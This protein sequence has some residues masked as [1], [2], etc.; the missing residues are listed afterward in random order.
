MSQCTITKNQR[1]ETGYI[2]GYTKCCKWQQP[3]RRFNVMYITNSGRVGRFVFSLDLFV[4]A[5]FETLEFSFRGSVFFGSMEQDIMCAI[6]LWLWAFFSS[7]TLPETM[8][9]FE[10][11]E[12]KFLFSYVFCSLSS[13]FFLRNSTVPQC[14]TTLTQNARR[15][16]RI[17]LS[18]TSYLAIGCK[19]FGCF[20]FNWFFVFC[21]RVE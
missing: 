11:S 4:P 20:W 14:M 13:N 3:F 18:V 9:A 10:A 15:K 6:A 21:L 16:L 19:N 7:R 17:I 12:G 2:R 8:I 1:Q 5:L